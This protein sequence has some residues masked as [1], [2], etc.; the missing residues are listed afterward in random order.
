MSRILFAWELG[1]GF[2]HLGPFRPI[3]EALLA[4]GHE[5]T[6]AARDV[7]NAATVLGALPLEIV[8]APLCVKT[9][10]GLAEPPLNFAE[11]LMRYGYLDAPQLGGLF[12]AWRGLLDIT[13]PNVL[14]AD[15]APT[16]LLAARGCNV[17]LAV[18][19]GAFCVPPPVS[20][21]PNMRDWVNVPAQRL[22]SSDETVLKV[23]NSILPATAPRLGALHEI[24]D[25]VSYLFNGVPEL[26]PFGPRDPGSFLGLHCGAAGTAVPQWPTG[27]GPRV[28]AY[29]N[30]E[31]RHLDAALAALAACGVRCLVYMRGDMPAVRQ[32]YA[33]PNFTFSAELLD[34]D[35]AV[36]AADLCVCHANYGTVMAV[37]RGGKPQLLLPYDLEK[38][39][40]AAAVERLGVGRMVHPEKEPVDIGG[41]LAQ[42]LGNP[43][44]TESAKAFALKHREPSIDTIIANTAQRIESLAQGQ[45]G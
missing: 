8:Q 28:F 29:L 20:P 32:K 25:R 14:V 24:F 39:L 23:I 41:A 13:R 30:G 27:R 5:L 33:G 11:I 6:V 36:R 9:Y 45:P 26:D 38:F 15:H 31:Y 18:T 44:F 2:G 43:A 4:H 1:A 10:N 21:T 7:Q 40:T 35:Q 22:A 34:I 12:R 17:A 16:A 19:G 3:A 42:L 37:L